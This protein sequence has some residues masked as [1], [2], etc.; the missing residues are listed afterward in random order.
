M[1]TTRRAVL[2]AG[3]AIVVAA[4]GYYAYGQL[5]KVAPNFADIAYGADTRNL[6]DVYLPE[7]AGPFPFVVEIHGGAFKLGDKAGN[8][9][10]TEV[11]AAGIAIVR[12]NY[13]F[14]ST[15]IWPA[16]GQD[17]L[18]A[19]A[20]IRAKAADY[21]L[22][23]ARMALW[24]QS[25]GA[26]LAVSTAISLAQSGAGAAAL[27][28]FYGPMDF[29]TMDS[30]MTELGMV[31]KMGQTSVEGSPESALLGFNV[32]DDPAKARS[33]GPI[34]RL[35]GASLS[36]PPVFIRHGEADD[37]IAHTQSKRLAEAWAKADPTAQVDFALVPGAGHG[38]SQ[39]T[40]AGV[41]TPLVAFLTSAL[42][43]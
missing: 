37:F 5:T 7:G 29:S 39:F 28:D 2:G 22:D 4:G 19:V 10:Q 20:F 1:T 43:P 3:A 26:F 33:I 35:E 11:L 12:I 32:A 34:A 15:A 18:D 41:V 21:N 17:C 30:D 14:S 31:A 24:G 6:L 36:L 40:A 9:V 38:T 42:A 13:R 8:P 25:A 23:P 16:Q 27:V